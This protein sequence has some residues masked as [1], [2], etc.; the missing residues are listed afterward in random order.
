MKLGTPFVAPMLPLA[1]MCTV[2]N[3]PQLAEAWQYSFIPDVGFV[4]RRRAH[5]QC[6]QHWPHALRSNAEVR[7]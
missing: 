6:F 7:Y 4:V 3:T 2:Y 5:R 1:A